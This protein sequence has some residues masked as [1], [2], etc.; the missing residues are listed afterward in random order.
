MSS[1]SPDP[2]DVP[3]PPTR[4][5][6]WRSLKLGY[7]AEPLLIVIAFVTTVGA[8]LPDALFALGLKLLADAVTEGSD[9]ANRRHRRPPGRP[10]HLDLVPEAG[11][12][13]GQPP[14]R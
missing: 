12:R 3:V 10:G 11:R 14:L 9:T 2:H 7:R 6:L 5:A 4:V 8:A 13:S 1:A